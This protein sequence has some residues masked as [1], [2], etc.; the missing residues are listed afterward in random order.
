[1]GITTMDMD[2]A[3]VYFIDDESQVLGALRRALRIRLKGWQMVFESSPS[4]ALELMSETAPWVV[5]VDK[6][7]PEIDGADFLQNVKDLYPEAVRV[8][9]SGDISHETVV[10]SSGVAHLL[11]SKPFE[12]EEIVEVVERAICLRSF[13]LAEDQRIAIGELDSLP[14]LP[15]NYNALVTYLDSVEEPDYVRVAELV[16]HDVAVLSKI[17]QLANS[18]F[19]G[20]ISPVY[21]AH[22]AVVRLG[23][24]LVRKLVL[25]FELYTTQSDSDLHKRLFVNAERVAEKCTE[26]ASLSGLK[27]PEIERAYFT[28]L[29]HNIGE[30]VITERELNI[31]SD[32]AGSFL[33]KLWGFEQK[34]VD[35]IRY[36]TSPENSNEKDVILYQLKIAKSLVQEN[37]DNVSTDLFLAEVDLNILKN[38]QLSDYAR[39]CS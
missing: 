24:D 39:S 33:L 8:I 12:L 15:A 9:L 38:A 16:S 6:K 4:H 30:L 26:L 7:M 35:S 25:F 1:M 3:A 10:E 37:P 5:V 20:M 21:S 23:H 22:D 31:A 11:L 18:A 32:L 27:K 13:Q 36:Q 19:W 28:G 34:I 17:L 14:I 2:Q 29:L